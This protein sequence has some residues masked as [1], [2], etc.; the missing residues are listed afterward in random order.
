MYEYQK[1]IYIL[2]GQI[3]FASSS[4]T[5][6]RLGESLLRN[7]RIPLRPLMIA[8]KMVKPGKRLGSILVNMN[9]ITPEEL[10]EG[11]RNQSQ[12]Y[13]SQFV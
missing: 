10:V 4:N 2:D 6:D 13:H 7:D 8:S 11:V 1:A 12:R 9:V 5:D 3:I